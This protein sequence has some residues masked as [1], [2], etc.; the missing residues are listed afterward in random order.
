MS[1]A[2]THSRIEFPRILKSHS[3]KSLIL[4]SC[5]LS[6]FTKKEKKKQFIWTDYD[7]RSDYLG[8][9][10]IFFARYHE[11]HFNFHFKKKKNIPIILKHASQ[12]FSI[13]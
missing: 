4:M 1:E 7:D 8:F 6:N 9:E 10:P 13:F 12:F 2:L 3:I 11:H 5:A